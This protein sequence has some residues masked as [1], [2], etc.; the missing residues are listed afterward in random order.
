M[1]FAQQMM[2]MSIVED[3]MYDFE[4]TTEKGQMR[5]R[6]FVGHRILSSLCAGIA[7]VTGDEKLAQRVCAQTRLRLITMSDEEIWQMAE[8]CSLHDRSPTQVYEQYVQI[9]RSIEE[10]KAT[11]DTWRND[12]LMASTL[13][14]EE[15]G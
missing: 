2:N 13:N 8:V 12:L 3:G 11:F 5:R 14:K 15:K 9:K 6:N 1:L 7:E 4:S 10:H